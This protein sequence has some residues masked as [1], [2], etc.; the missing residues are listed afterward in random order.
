M[1]EPVIE[2]P[3]VP[4]RLSSY[5][6]ILAYGDSILEQLI[7]SQRY[8]Y[9][10]NHDPT[11]NSSIIYPPSP[12]KL[13]GA[14]ST[15][16]RI[17]FGPKI[18]SPLNHRSLTTLF[19]GFVSF[20]ESFVVVGDDSSHSSAASS[21]SSIAVL[22]NSALWDVLSDEATTTIG[23]AA[24]TPDNN[25]NN[26]DEPEPT[27]QQYRPVGGTYRYI[28]SIFDVYWYTTTTTLSKNPT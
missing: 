10:D 18:A 24:M 22:L 21:S 4:N 20:I 12:P 9:D 25:N 14:A 11:M 6:I 27:T 13:A 28:A 17:H 15:G 7:A 2:I 23:R 26:N 16:G 19:N 5:D 3:S 8:Y 1:L